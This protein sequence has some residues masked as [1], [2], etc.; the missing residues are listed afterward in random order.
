MNK[1]T[2]KQQKE[3]LT[4]EDFLK[5]LFKAA[6]IVQKPKEG[7]KRTSGVNLSGGYN[8][9]NTHSDKTEAI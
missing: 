2:N 7:K 4:K 5:A 9:K 6:K 1:K 8:G 3:V